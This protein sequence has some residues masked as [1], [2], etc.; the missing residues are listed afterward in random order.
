MSGYCNYLKPKLVQ[1][2]KIT[3]SHT[4]IYVV[5]PF[6]NSIYENSLL[7]YAVMVNGDE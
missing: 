7:K 5:F 4:H 3:R 2:V 6:Q 1:L